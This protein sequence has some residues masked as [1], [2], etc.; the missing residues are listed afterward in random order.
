MRYEL[1]ITSGNVNNDRLQT[2]ILNSVEEIN[3][4][5]GYVAEKV[6]TEK[7]VYNKDYTEYQGYFFHNSETGKHIGIFVDAYEQSVYM[8]SV[9]SLRRVLND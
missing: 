2:E 6:G 4:F 1:T 9:T 8:K 7:Q 5:F 3:E